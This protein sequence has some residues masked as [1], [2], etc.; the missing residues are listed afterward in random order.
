ML[1][2]F[3]VMKCCRYLDSHGGSINGC[4]TG[5]V[6]GGEGIVMVVEMYLPGYC[7]LLY[8]VYSI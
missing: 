4:N 1:G 5:R 8:D 7:T 6:A 3:S 2:D